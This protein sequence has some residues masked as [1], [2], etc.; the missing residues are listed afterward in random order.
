MSAETSNLKRKLAISSLLTVGAV[1]AVSLWDYIHSGGIYTDYPIENIW[2]AIK[3]SGANGWMSP[4]KDVATGSGVAGSILAIAR[5]SRLSISETAPPFMG[6]AV[7][8]L[9]Y[10]PDLYRSTPD[11]LIAMGGI[12]VSFTYF[13]VGTFVGIVPGALYRVFAEISNRSRHGGG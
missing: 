12:A 11:S 3:Y 13:L 5:G 6:L 10:V 1:G 7:S 2:E 9:P 8:T 4:L